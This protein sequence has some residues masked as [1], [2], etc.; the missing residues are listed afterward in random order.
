M[1]LNEYAKKDTEVSSQGHKADHSESTGES[2]NV[3]HNDT[4]I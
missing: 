1:K 2:S 3:L 4:I